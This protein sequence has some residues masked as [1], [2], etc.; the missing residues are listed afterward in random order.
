MRR[1][2]WAFLCTTAIAS[3]SARFEM[4]DERN[5][6][7]R[8][9]SRIPVRLEVVRDAAPNPYIACPRLLASVRDPA[10]DG[11]RWTARS[12]G[13]IA[14][15]LTLEMSGLE[16]E[17]LRVVVLDTRKSRHAGRPCLPGQRHIHARSDRGA[18]PRRRP[19]QCGGRNPCHN[20]P[21]GDPTPSPDDLH[22]TAEA[23]AAGKLLDI[24]LLDHLVIGRDAYVSLRDRG[25]G[26]SV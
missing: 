19:H 25:I 6:L 7:R 14:D 17:Q 26:F 18:V 21:S 8:R 13:D 1:I 15:R 12:P 2:A 9:S 20:H 22:L 10:L 4:T 11:T 24:R 23:L 3:G 16:Q 5:Q